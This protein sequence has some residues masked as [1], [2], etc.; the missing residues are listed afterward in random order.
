[1][2]HLEQRSTR[3]YRISGVTSS[4][5]WVPNLP[6]PAGLPA[7]HLVAF[8]LCSRDDSFAAFTTTSPS[9]WSWLRASWPVRCGVERGVGRGLPKADPAGLSP[10]VLG[11]VGE[12]DDRLP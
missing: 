8:A 6:L 4:I 10:P 2:G 11:R 12:V 9:P 7:D 5:I 1:M 3:F